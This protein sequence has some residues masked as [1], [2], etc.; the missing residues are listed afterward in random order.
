MFRVTWPNMDADDWEGSTDLDH[1]C[2]QIDQWLT[3]HHPPEVGG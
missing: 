1:V 3:R 2:R